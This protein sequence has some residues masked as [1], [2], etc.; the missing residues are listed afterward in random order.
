[1]RGHRLQNRHTTP[2]AISGVSNKSKAQLVM[3]RTSRW[4]LLAIIFVLIVIMVGVG[5]IVRFSTNKQLAGTST[6]TN[7]AQA[8]DKKDHETPPIYEIKTPDASNKPKEESVLP[9]TE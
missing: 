7:T 5:L 1:M 2:Q 9:R 4:R 3:A 6:A 8:T